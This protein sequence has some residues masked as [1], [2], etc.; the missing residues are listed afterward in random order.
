MPSH[1]LI[2]RVNCQ[3]WLKLV[4]NSND[5]GKALEKGSNP[6]LTLLLLPL[7]S[8]GILA[9]AVLTTEL[10]IFRTMNLLAS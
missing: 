10:Q 4:I 5:P 7:E 6:I 9:V 1:H 8:E 3:L 2:L